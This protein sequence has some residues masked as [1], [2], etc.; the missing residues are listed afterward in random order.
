M[1]HNGL[2]SWNLLPVV[3]ALLKTYNNWLLLTSSPEYTPSQVTLRVYPNPCREF[4]TVSFPAVGNDSDLQLVL[5]NGLGQ[6][7]L[8]TSDFSAAPGGTVCRLNDLGS[9]SAGM[10]LIQLLKDGEIIGTSRLVR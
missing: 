3:S 2:T 5:R 7:V 6:S 4:T 10:Y 8:V 9:L 1:N